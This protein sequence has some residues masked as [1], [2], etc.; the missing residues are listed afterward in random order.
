MNMFRARLWIHD[1]FNT[2]AWGRP[3]LPRPFARAALP[4][5]LT[6]LSVDECVS[7]AFSFGNVY[8]GS[9]VYACP[10]VKPRLNDHPVSRLSSWERL[11]N[12]GLGKTTQLGTWGHISF[13]DKKDIPLPTI[14][15]CELHQMSRAIFL[16]RESHGRIEPAIAAEI[17]LRQDETQIAK[18]S[19][20]GK[21]L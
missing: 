15:A 6:F 19:V 11:D 21:L 20:R 14:W 7:G 1:A 16:A 5:L 9:N 10:G 12:T 8:I 18:R 17:G 2:N 13:T 3:R 4:S